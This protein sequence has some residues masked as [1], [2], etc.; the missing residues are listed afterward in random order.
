MNNICKHCQEIKVSACDLKE[1]IAKYCKQ[2]NE[3]CYDDCR[4]I[5]YLKQLKGK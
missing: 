5:Y 3:L 1:F 2:C 4:V